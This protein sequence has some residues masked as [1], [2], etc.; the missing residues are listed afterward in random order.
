MSISEISSSH[1]PVKIWSPLEEV[2]S[3]ALTQLRNTASD[4]IDPITGHLPLL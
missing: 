2:E 1:V 3:A 4:E